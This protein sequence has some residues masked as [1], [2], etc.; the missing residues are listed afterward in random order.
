MRI[1]VQFQISITIINYSRNDFFTTAF[2]YTLLNERSHK[3]CDCCS[4]PRA[5]EWDTNTYLYNL[6]LSAAWHLVDISTL[7]FD[8]IKLSVK[9]ASNIFPF[10]LVCYF[11]TK[12]TTQILLKCTYDLRNSIVYITKFHLTSLTRFSYGFTTFIHNTSLSDLVG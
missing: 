3:D 7:S 10:K 8:Y 5:S 6:G 9:R 12:W 4:E 1:H 11:Q 2:I